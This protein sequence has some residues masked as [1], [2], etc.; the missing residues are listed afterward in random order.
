MEPLNKLV[1]KFSGRPGSGEF[2]TWKE[3]LLQDFTLS[4]ITSPVDQVT[5]ISFLFD[6]DAAEYYPSLTKAVQDDWSKLMRLL[7]QRFDCISHEPVYLS[8][9]LSLK[10]SDFSPTCRLRD[11][12]SYLRYQVEG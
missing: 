5:I 2:R 6:G 4:D 3:E 8:R 12:I 9:M 1:K 10:E 11:R 7:G